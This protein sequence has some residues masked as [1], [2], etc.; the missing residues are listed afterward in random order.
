[1]SE[2][3]LRTLT[4]REAARFWTK[5]G[6]LSFGGPAG[7]IALMHT[8]LVVRRRWISEQRFAHALNYCLLL[9]GP[10]AQQLATYIGWL[11][12]GTRGGLTAGILFILPGFLVILA[13]STLYVTWGQLPSVVATLDGVKPAVVAMVIAALIRMSRRTLKDPIT[14]AIAL[15]AAAA[16]L[17]QRVPFPLIVGLA[18]MI[19]LMTRS[20]RVVSE[21]HAPPQKG[22]V[23]SESLVSEA[24]RPV[25]DDDY[26]GPSMRLG[27]GR[28]WAHASVGIVLAIV[29]LA[30][31]ITG[32][33]RDGIFAQMAQLFT[34]AALVTFGGAYAVL[35]YVAQ[36]SVEQYG[37]LQPKQMLDGLALGETTP[38]P[39]I[40]IVTFVGFVG[41]WQRGGMGYAGALLG[42]S[43]AT[44]FTF[45]PSF[46]FIL[47]GAPAVEHTRRLPH[48]GA[49]LS[50]ISAAVVGV[51]A[52]LAI[53]L[54]RQVILPGGLW[55]W[56]DLAAL[57]V[58]VVSLLALMRWSVSIPW[59]VAVTAGL[60]LL[61]HLLA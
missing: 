8:E 13:L 44:Y 11:L 5:L 48:F 28:W 14:V 41:G 2:N 25:I 24:A 55:H 59:L 33:G 9:P 7:Q 19:G 30:L 20:W 51:V 42:A 50:G 40:L 6:F 61:R 32:Q 17:S 1:M 16:M 49:A 31:L 60:G 37:W 52:Q 21:G 38:G 47:L 56:P 10:E 46:L 54:G 22:G 4:F 35:P 15:A 58:A 26:V 23:P 34:S 18:A 57:A 39:L 12:H 29:P 43:I 27:R 36:A 45:L 53:N 3:A